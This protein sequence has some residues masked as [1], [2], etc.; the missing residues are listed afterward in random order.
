MPSL[1][2]S[3]AIGDCILSWGTNGV[4]G[5]FLP[6][7]GAAEHPGSHPPPLA[8]AELV[9]RIR[10][11]LEGHLD[12]FSDV[13]YDWTRVTSFRKRVLG[14]VLAV[15]PRCTATYAAIAQAIGAGSA[16]RAVGG[17]LAANPWPLLVPCHRIV[18]SGGRLTGYSGGGGLPMKARLLALEQSSAQ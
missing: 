4:T 13:T 8:I 10:L 17:A 12:D 7:S 14:A 11:H 3:T 5:F 18:G 2:F 9:G 1:T 16:T 6:Q 15:G